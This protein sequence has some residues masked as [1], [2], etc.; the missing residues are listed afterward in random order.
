M[1]PLMEREF[2]ARGLELALRVGG[3]AEAHADVASL[4]SDSGSAGNPRVVVLAICLEQFSASF[5][6][7]DWECEAACAHVLELAELAVANT[8]A[9]IVLN[10]VLPPLAPVHGFATVSERLDHMSRVETLNLALRKLAAA[11]PGRVVLLDWVTYARELGEVDT[12]D[13]RFWYNSGLPFSQKFLRRYARDL[14]AIAESVVGK[15]RKCVVLDCDN[16]LWGGVIGEDGLDG[17]RLSDNSV[18]GAYYQEFQRCILDLRARGVLV[19]LCSKNNDSDVF[20][21]LDQHPHCLIR[22]QHLA[23]WRI[24][25]NDKAASV[26][27]IASELNIG[28]D[29]LVFID[30]SAVEC[31]RIREAC[32][33]VLVLQTPADAGQLPRFLHEQAPCPALAITEMDE[34]RAAAYQE[35]RAREEFKAAVADLNE[36]K[37][38][39][40]TWIRPRPVA[41]AD[42]PR[43]SQLFQRTNQFNLNGIRRDAA[44]VEEML[45][46][47]SCLVYCADIGDKF[48]DL[49]LVAVGVVRR[50]DGDLLMDA[51][52]M[53]CRA[54]GRDAEFAFLRCLLAEAQARWVSAEA[55]RANYVAT[56]RNGMVVEFLRRAGFRHAAGSGDGDDGYL[57]ALPEL[58]NVNER[59]FVEIKES[60]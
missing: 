27:E 21:V 31:E 35:G 55:I 52:L 30:D 34:K 59:R 24:N 54:L 17:I 7:H 15:V 36:F 44:A 13:R 11:N 16:T 33:G 4:S 37:A 2:R 14:A 45:A 50:S 53:S 60:Q 58:M 40:G 28:L 49:G 5:G 20:Q 25:W 47:E 6:H 9:T 29:S 1:L 3:F 26:V 22:R 41:L 51:F 48:G 32:P 19:A 12:Y 46:D 38:R 39:L 57:G 10:S 43:V 8:S 23:A 18:P 56:A 42:V